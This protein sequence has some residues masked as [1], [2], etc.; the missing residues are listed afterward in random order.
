M[1]QFYLTI[2]KDIDKLD[3]ELLE[4]IK[5]CKGE[6][7]T[8][9]DNFKWMIFKHKKLSRSYNELLRYVKENRVSIKLINLL[10]N[11]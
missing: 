1:L 10:R 4:K 8:I 7:V 6:T 2:T 9:P 5:L 3:Q 11:Y